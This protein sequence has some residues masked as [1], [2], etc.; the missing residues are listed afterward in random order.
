MT[1]ELLSPDSAFDLELVQQDLLSDLVFLI[2]TLISIYQNKK[3]EQ[4]IINPAEN[5]SPAGDYPEYEAPFGFGPIVLVLFLIGTAILA[6]AAIQ[7]LNKEK[8]EAGP[9]PDQTTINNLNGG[10]MVI[11]GQ[12]VRITGYI[13]S[14]L[15]EQIRAANP[16]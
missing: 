2:G 3:A 4:E 7:R 9:N 10:E 13:I 6:F 1:T 11:F 14:I 12:F 5:Q 8:Y 15:G 16:I